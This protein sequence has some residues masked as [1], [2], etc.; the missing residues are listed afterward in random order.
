MANGSAGGSSKWHAVPNI[1]LAQ[2]H[3]DPRDWNAVLKVYAGQP[4]LALGLA[5]QLT[6]LKQLL[7]SGPQGIPV[8]ITGLNK[9]IEHLYPHTSF[10]Q[11]GRRLYHHTIQSTIT[12]K[13]E[14]L[15]TALEKSLRHSK[16]R[17][18]LITRSK[19]KTT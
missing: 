19:V 16:R 6:A 9:A 15:L 3:V 13:E 12:L 14:D 17:I 8:A 11:I 1:V 18:S 2:N 4:T 5:Y 10:H 7:Q